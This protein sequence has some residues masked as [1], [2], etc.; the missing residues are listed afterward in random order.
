M[1]KH[2]WLVFWNDCIGRGR[3]DLLWEDLEDI[4]FN[5]DNV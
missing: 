5:R 1:I 2:L 4:V 3:W